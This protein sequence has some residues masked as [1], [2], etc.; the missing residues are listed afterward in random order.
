MSKHAF[1][2]IGHF[3]IIFL[4][5][6]CTKSV[7][8]KNLENTNHRELKED[9][10]SHKSQ[11]KAEA[12][13][14]NNNSPK[15]K[16]IKQLHLFPATSTIWKKTDIKVC[17]ENRGAA[18]ENERQWIID[19]LNETWSKYSN[20]NFHGWGKCKLFT[21]GIRIK[22]SDS[23]PH[24]KALGRKID[25]YPD[26]MVLN[27]TFKNW[28]PS[29]ATSEE[30]RKFC[31]RAI[32]VHEFGHALGFAHEQNRDDRPD[33]CTDSPQGS[34]GDV[35]LGVWDL[36]SVMNY[37]NPIYSNAGILSDIDMLGVRHYYSATHPEHDIKDYRF[38]FNLDTFRNE[39]KL[40]KDVSI[41]QS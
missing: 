1:S 40:T 3:S 35:Y 20:L 5:A 38:T 9:Q 13:T 6:S 8:M 16:E 10:F 25:G 18:P 15:E 23:G 32:A 24:V 2:I 29:C 26:G 21:S 30:K 31:I 39:K 11:S 17:W 7:R 28:S 19:A 34:N 22:I 27:F 36:S 12:N 33:S 37:C 4:L 41:R 14:E